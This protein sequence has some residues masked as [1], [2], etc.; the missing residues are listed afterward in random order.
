M[1]VLAVAVLFWVFGAWA[2]AQVVDLDK[3]G[4]LDALKHAN[5]THHAKVL[6]AMEQVQAV[7]YEPK[8]QHNLSLNS[9]KPDPTRRQI[10]TS[11]PAKTR[12][13][14]PIEDETYRI[15]VVYLKDPA[16]LHRTK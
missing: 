15:T 8:G 10:E 5:P 14:I 1:R 13:T 11:H 3:A 9:E 2:A 4:A 12:L 16:T 6:A 7:P